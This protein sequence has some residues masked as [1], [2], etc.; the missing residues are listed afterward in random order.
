[1]IPT[2][3]LQLL[4]STKK[5]NFLDNLLFISL[6]LETSFIAKKVPRYENKLKIPALEVYHCNTDLNHAQVNVIKSHNVKYDEAKI[7]TSTSN[8]RLYFSV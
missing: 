1:M 6:P 3:Y 5:I 8:F 7:L 2:F 4:L